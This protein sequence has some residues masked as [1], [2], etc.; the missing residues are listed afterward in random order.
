MSHTGMILNPAVYQEDLC[1]DPNLDRPVWM[2]QARKLKF[3][4]I[5]M[6]T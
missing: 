5:F 3:Y 2:T 6:S 1:D 4:S